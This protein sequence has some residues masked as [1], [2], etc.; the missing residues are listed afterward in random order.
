MSLLRDCT[1]IRRM[2]SYQED[3][4]QNSTTVPNFV[5]P[6]AKK[7]VKASA[8]KFGARLFSLHRKNSDH[9]RVN[10][11]AIKWYYCFEHGDRSSKLLD[12]L[13]RLCWDVKSPFLGYCLHASQ[14]PFG[15]TLGSLGCLDHNWSSTVLLAAIW[16]LDTSKF[17]I[18]TLDMIWARKTYLAKCSR[19]P[20]IDWPQAVYSARMLQLQLW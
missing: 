7:L 1:P 2:N 3:A 17:S 8:S 15:S 11:E 9:H 16:S 20:H 18:G 12:V 13:V 6:L 5:S 14:R 4:L 10:A 19:R